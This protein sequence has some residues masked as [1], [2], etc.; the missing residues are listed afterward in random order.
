MKG[1]RK[2]LGR[3][4]LQW[5]KRG[6]LLAR[7]L[8][9]VGTRYHCPCCGWSLRS[10]VDKSSFFRKTTD[11][12]CP[13]CN[14]K[15]RHRRDWLYLQE[16]TPFFDADLEV[17]EIAPWWSFG[18]GF[19]RA[20]NLRYSAIDLDPGAPFV[21]KAGDVTSIPAPSAHFDVVVCIHV[22]EHVDDDR[23]A[24]EEIFRVLK[25]GGW[26]F[27]TVP[28]LLDEPTRE[29]PSVTSPEDR[30][31][32]FGEKGHVRYYGRDIQERL[33]GAGF[34]VMF[35]PASNITEDDRLR[36]GLRR[37]ENIFL[38]TRPVAR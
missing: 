33:A 29:D 2:L 24:M 34:D 17:L 36:Y 1:L 21:S 15:A 14:S 16:K 31:R 11:S 12:C 20:P 4:Q 38:C 35:E 5:M 3:S 9:F 19:S 26:A 32:L 37:D 18:R 28:L 25:P 30:E 13:R 7:G 27:I 6:V 10:F 8:F 22:L 23:K